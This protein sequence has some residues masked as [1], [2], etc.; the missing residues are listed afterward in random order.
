V[1]IVLAGL[2]LRARHWDRP[3]G[4]ECGHQSQIILYSTARVLHESGW[5]ATGG[6]LLFD[7]LPAEAH[8]LAG[9]EQIYRS[10]S[11]LPAFLLAVFMHAAGDLQDGARWFGITGSLAALTLLLTAWR[12]L[13]WRNLVVAGLFAIVPAEVH[14]SRYPWM[15]SWE[16]ALAIATFLSLE[17]YRTR[18]GAAPFAVLCALLFVG[19]LFSWHVVAVL[20]VTLLALSLDGGRPR[21]LRLAACAACAS[22]AILGV[23]PWVACVAARTG[24]DICAYIAD[25]FLLRTNLL[26]ADQQA[27]AGWEVLRQV[28]VERQEAFVTPALAW[29]ALAWVPIGLIGLRTK[30]DRLPLYAFGTAAV[31]LGGLYEATYHHV[32]F[33]YYSALW[34]C[35]A[36][37]TVLG[38]L[39][40][41]GRGIGVRRALAVAWAAVF[42]W[43]AVQAR[44]RLA[45]LQYVPSHADEI[46]FLQ[47]VPG[48]CGP[49]ERVAT[50]DDFGGPRRDGDV[51][52]AS[53]TRECAMHRLCEY[54]VAD[55]PRF[56][57]FLASPGAALFYFRKGKG[58]NRPASLLLM[59]HLRA[60]YARVAVDV[61]GEMFDLRR[62]FEDVGYRAQ[63]GR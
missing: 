47:Q 18:G 44:E 26:E 17:R 57:A 14:F 12:P 40:R 48:R 55:L 8:V 1:A 35:L 45:S 7:S 61:H 4:S 11:A 59:R 43:Q 56:R 58:S 34:S 2:A 16:T 13:G 6:T 62:R 53:S 41:P 54:G 9:G 22:S 63:S 46:R 20:A 29:L 31:F 36:G 60:T 50:N 3:L 19:A 33:N 5:W 32:W 37:A 21:L 51:M 24:T 25:R 15:F 38:V 39:V 49:T 28:F 27:P 23:L 30:A 10:N 42:A 52:R